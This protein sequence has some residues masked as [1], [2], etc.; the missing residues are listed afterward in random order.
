MPINRRQLLAG[1]ASVAGAL[2]M[3]PLMS[4][5]LAAIKARAKGRDKHP[6]RFVFCIKSNGLW[7]EM[8]QPRG[9]EDRLPFEV[10]YDAKGRLINSKNG[11]IRKT[12]TVAADLALGADVKLSE[13]MEP[14]EPYRR[15]ISILQGV[16]SGFGTYHM[17][18]YQTLGAFQARNRNSTETLGPT[19]DALLARAFPRPMPHV[20]L[21]HDPRSPSG[22][23]YVP[24]SAAGRGKPMPFYTKPK[25][26]YKELFGVVDQGAAKKNYDTQSD[27]LDFFVEDAKR[28][29][30]Q[31]A[32]PE[33]EQ[34]DRYLG[35]FDSIRRSRQEIEA[36][37]EQL[38]KY[39]PTP[40]G[41]IKAHSTM[42]VGEGNI[43]I[44]A[45]AL[46]SGL[47]NVVTLR[48]DLLGSSSYEGVGGLH[49]GVGHGQVKNIVN[50]RRTI[51]NYHFK[52]IAR[53][54]KSLQAI[55]EGDGTM[56]DNTVIVY[57]SDNGE[58]HHSSGVNYPIVL[59]GDLG[60]RLAKG[61]YFAPGNDAK[62][63]R[64]K[65]EYTRLGDVWAT[66]LAAAGQPHKD[67]GIPVNGVPHKPIESL[68]G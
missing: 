44:A 57:T 40:P 51:C 25:R 30:A 32:G 4:S 5:V 52:Q 46:L 18:C 29:Q 12:P 35:A 16:N 3:S 49:G 31:V 64:S 19:V 8:V 36:M 21:G 48:F 1:T 38:R 15:R 41:E 24:T 33:R 9:L 55:P 2:Q 34:L 65:S 66:L 37:S 60:G 59:L 26:A 43:D 10:A 6:L 39:A 23:A 56:L 7:A 20:C 50:A 63:D 67:F 17:G 54:C 58:T 47:T 61:R 62:I 27:I 22:V 68:L 53:L 42:K 45:A 13:V 11:Q 14:L 28:L